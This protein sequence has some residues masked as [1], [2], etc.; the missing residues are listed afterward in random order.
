MYYSKI[1]KTSWA[2]LHTSSKIRA[3]L[4]EINKKYNFETDIFHSLGLRLNKPTQGKIY[5]INTINPIMSIHITVY[6][7]IFQLR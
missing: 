4:G 1:F 3:E 2:A 5:T 7:H 6:S